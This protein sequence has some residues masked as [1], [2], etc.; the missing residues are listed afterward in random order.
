MPAPTGPATAPR[1][2]LGRSLA[3]G[4]LGAGAALLLLAGALATRSALLLTWAATAPGTVVA[5]ERRTPGQEG[6]AAAVV[7]FRTTD[8]A[9]H[10]IR[11]ALWSSPPEFAVGEAVEVVYDAASP[12]A[13]RIRS[14]PELW[15]VP[16]VLAAAGLPFLAIGLAGLARPRPPR[17]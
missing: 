4:T 10:L 17:G 7:R 9:E 3:L 11:S 15:A 6:S 5:L 13:A 8:G 1:P 14:F 12:A 16:V 2:L